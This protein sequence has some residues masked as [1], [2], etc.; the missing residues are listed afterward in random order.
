LKVLFLESFARDLKRIRDKDLRER[1]RQVIEGLERSLSL[2]TVPHLKKLQGKGGFFRIR[3]GDLRLGLRVEGD[4]VTLM[5]I[6]DR[7][8]IYRHFP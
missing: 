4:K 6:L 1:V 3:V 2:D 8:E 5:R 7:K